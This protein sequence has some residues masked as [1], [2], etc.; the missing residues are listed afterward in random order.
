[1]VF[2]VGSA[3]E[4]L[5]LHGTSEFTMV[6]QGFPGLFFHEDVETRKIKLFWGELVAMLHSLPGR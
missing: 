4:E 1:V 2:T 3:V 6:V 5:P